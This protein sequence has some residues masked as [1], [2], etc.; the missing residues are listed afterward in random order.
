M[1][2]F[3]TRTQKKYAIGHFEQYNVTHRER[4]GREITGTKVRGKR[5]EEER[6]RQRSRQR[7]RQSLHL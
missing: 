3:M 2:N 7:D 4:G 1:L 5:V 6:Q